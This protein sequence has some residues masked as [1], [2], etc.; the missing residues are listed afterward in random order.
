[1]EDPLP[2]PQ[3]DERFVE[4]SEVWSQLSAEQQKA[5]V[6]LLARMAYN[7]ILARHDTYTER[8]EWENEYHHE[9]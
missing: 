4:P 2:R 1:M 8:E 5:I 3:P 7:H 6:R 9:G